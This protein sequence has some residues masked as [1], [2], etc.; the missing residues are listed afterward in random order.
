MVQTLPIFDPV[1]ADGVGQALGYKLQLEDWVVY[2]QRLGR[3]TRYGPTPPAGSTVRLTIRYRKLD[4]RRV[5]LDADILDPAGNLWLRLDNWHFWRILWPKELNAFSRQPR[6][7]RVGV[8]WPIKNERAFCCRVSAKMFGEISPDWI[9]RYCL[10]APEWALYRQRP[11]FDWLLGR[12]ALKDAVRDWVRRRDGRVLMPLEVEIGTSPSGQ[13]VVLTPADGPAV[14]VAHVGD[15]AIALVGDAR[16]LGIDLAE[17][18]RPMPTT[19]ATQGPDD[20]AFDVAEQTILNRAEGD[21]KSWRYRCWCARQ[22]VAK[23]LE[24]GTEAL[25]RLR[26][27]GLHPDGMMEIELLPENRRFNV[28]TYLDGKHAIA[29]AVLE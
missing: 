23:A 1:L 25:S 6:Q 18:G 13:P 4:A 29:A 2:P 24:L 10:T 7:R 17:I 8:S 11:R 15:E 5:E 19:S 9:A 28:E 12:I 27:R 20:S 16:S 14:S 21:I 22:A 3:L 26:L